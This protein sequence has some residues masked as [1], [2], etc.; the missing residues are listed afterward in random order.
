MTYLRKGNIYAFPALH[1]CMEIAVE[2]KKIFEAVQPDCV[3]VE[4]PQCFEKAFNHAASRLPDIS[5]IFTENDDRTL[6]YLAEPCDAAF[7]GMRSA[8]ERGVP[9]FCI[10]KE[11]SHYQAHSDLL[12]DPYAISIIGLN[13]YHDAY[14]QKIAHY[15]RDSQDHPREVYMARRLK[16]L[17]L[18]Y[19]RILFIG[20]FHHVTQVLDLVDRE[21]FPQERISEKPS[22]IA[23]LKE[24]SMR[25]VMAECGWIS[26]AFEVWRTGDLSAPLDRQKLI[27]SLYQEA[28]KSYVESTGNAFQQCN[29]RT[30]MKFARNYSLLH[31]RLMPDLHKILLAA[32]GCVDHN[33]AY[34]VWSQATDF[35]YLKNRESLPE[36][37]LTP[38]Q[39]WGNAKKILFH[40][41]SKRRKGYDFQKRKHHSQIKFQPPSPWN[42]CSY[43]PE[44]VIVEK[45]GEYLKK[46]GR[47]LFK[48]ESTRS[49]PF[50]TSLEDGL[51]MRE[52]I[53][54]W[55]QKKIYVRLQGHPKGNASS[56]VVIFNEEM[57]QSQEKYPWKTTWIGEHYQESDMAFYATH[58]STNVVGPGISRCEYG[59]F[60]LS[61]PPCRLR[62]IWSDPDYVD[63][64]SKSEVLLMAAVDYSL[65]SLIV[66][67]ADR[68]PRSKLRSTAARFG[69]KIL[70]VPLSQISSNLL[71]KIRIFHVLDGHDKR[72]IAGDYIF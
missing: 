71:K 30:L 39:V 62:D 17:S 29:L 25:E 63:L 21:T 52:T 58:R 60:M 67:V 49:L 6:Y 42:I 70:F 9:A 50:T 10:D 69:K 45:F 4:L 35:S 23:T 33:Y 15:P 41:K 14:Q 48:E 27:F 16:E 57:V 37:N 34:E 18:L 32:R 46:K 53:R 1:Y 51:D 43:P 55:P 36:L 64:P 54:H 40:L 11:V 38:Q 28:A 24:E 2:T 8:L 59:G 44:D 68:P 13:A 66:Y 22:Q 31:L 47:F 56:V 19:D 26:S 12:P 3:A 61:S 7:E 20:G 65:Q 5:I 72:E